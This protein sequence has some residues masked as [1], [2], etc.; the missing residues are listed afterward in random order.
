MV[1]IDHLD[2]VAAGVLRWLWFLDA[3][4]GGYTR[5]GV[6]GWARRE[7]AEAGTGMLLPEVL[8]R[9]RARGYVEEQEVHLPGSRPVTIYRITGLGDLVLARYEGR[10]PRPPWPAG[11]PGEDDRAVYLPAGPS[12]ALAQLRKA[13]T[14][15]RP[16]AYPGA[17]SGWR[18]EDELRE[19]PPEPLIDHWDTGPWLPGDPPWSRP[20]SSDGLEAPTHFDRVDL[21]WLERVELCQR[22]LFLPEHR[23]R[24]VTLWRITV[25]GLCV[26]ELE[27]HDPRQR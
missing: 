14:D 26:E 11:E 21:L 19:D 12:A 3:G 23:T 15:T 4:A 7:D 22:T 17:G 10:E 27:W 25:E 1:R 13:V 2:K 6:R 9:L 5:R 8:P 20:S 16:P 18:T 24:P